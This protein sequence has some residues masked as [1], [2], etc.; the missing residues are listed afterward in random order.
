M[1]RHLAAVERVCAGDPAG[2]PM[3]ALPQPDRFHWLVA[4]RSTLIQTSPVHA[5]VCDDPAA[6]LE[7]I[8]DTVVRTGPRRA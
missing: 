1:R 8:V 5:G 2:G 3:A 4:P 6:E 7:R